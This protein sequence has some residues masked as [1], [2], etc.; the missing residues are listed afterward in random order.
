MTVQTLTKEQP[1]EMIALTRMDMRKY[2]N[3]SYYYN[4]HIIKIPY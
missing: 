4:T 3:L 1:E 2:N